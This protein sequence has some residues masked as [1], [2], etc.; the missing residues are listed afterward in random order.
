MVADSGEWVPKVISRCRARGANI[1]ANMTESAERS[2]AIYSVEPSHFGSPAT[3]VQRAII[4]LIVTFI[5]ELIEFKLRKY[6]GLTFAQQLVRAGSI[7]AFVAGWYWW[8]YLRGRRYLLEVR[9]DSIIQKAG[10]RTKTFYPWDIAT[11]SE[12][13]DPL[14][15]PGQLVRGYRSSLFIPEGLPAYEDVKTKIDAIK[16]S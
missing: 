2:V 12:V 1:P 11:V 3:R 10:E 7:A 16:R 15:V 13:R 6:L 5:F 9:P 8:L 14:S 4:V